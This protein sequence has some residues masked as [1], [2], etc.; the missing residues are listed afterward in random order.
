[1]CAVVLI[2]NQGSVSFRNGP[3]SRKLQDVHMAVVSRPR[4]SR[5]ATRETQP[6][7]RSYSASGMPRAGAV[8]R[9]GKTALTRMIRTA[10]TEAEP[11][12]FSGPAPWALRTNWTRALKSGIPFVER[13]AEGAK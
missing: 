10:D 12:R 8:H 13:Q 2:R 11:A 6:R 9:I 1:M 7:P 3:V 5:G 4:A